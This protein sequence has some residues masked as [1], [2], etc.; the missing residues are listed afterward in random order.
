M[1]IRGREAGVGDPLSTHTYRN[2][3][4]F[5]DILYVYAN[6]VDPDQTRSV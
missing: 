4:K 6:S 5:S 2:D 3:P 1:G